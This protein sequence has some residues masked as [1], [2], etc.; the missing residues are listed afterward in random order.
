MH[1][2]LKESH[3]HKPINSEFPLSGFSSGQEF[4]KTQTSTALLI[5]HNE[6]TLDDSHPL[7]ECTA[8]PECRR[9]DFHFKSI[10]QCCVYSQSQSSYALLKILIALLCFH[11]RCAC[12]PAFNCSLNSG[13]SADHYRRGGDGLRYRIQSA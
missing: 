8:S 9:L 12:D 7:S 1:T 13:V 6:Y 11:C 3:V 4:V 10:L 2:H 5:R